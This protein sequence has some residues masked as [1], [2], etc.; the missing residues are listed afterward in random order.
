MY[1]ND[2]LVFARTFPP[3]LSLGCLCPVCRCQSP[4]VAAAAG[5]AV[6]PRVQKSRPGLAGRRMPRRQWIRTWVN[7]NELGEG[8]EAECPGRGGLDGGGSGTEGLRR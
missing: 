1:T 2:T 7:L 6:L 3:C 8:K 4:A 5:L